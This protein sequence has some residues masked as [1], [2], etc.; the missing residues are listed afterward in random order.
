MVDKKW[1][2]VFSLLA[3]N[4]ALVVLALV[5]IF[6]GNAVPEGSVQYVLYIGLNDRYTYEQ[7]IPTDKA[8]EIVNEIFVRH[9]GGYTVHHAF[10]G[11]LDEYGVFTQENTLVYTILYASR[12]Q[13]YAIM[14]EVLVALNQN[15]ILVE[16]RVTYSFFYGGE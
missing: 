5:Y 7:I 10:G 12:E 13:I 8:L 6:F 15:S 16:R 4:F 9:V 14:D 1:A 3:V 11:W 2:V